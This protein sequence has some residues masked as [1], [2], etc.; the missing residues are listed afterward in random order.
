MDVVAHP[1]PVDLA[2]DEGA[3]LLLRELVAAWSPHPRRLR[4]HGVDETA[5]GAVVL[6]AAEP[7][8]AFTAVADAAQDLDVPSR[9]P[10]AVARTLEIAGALAGLGHA[11]RDVSP[12]AI[13]FD[14]DGRAVLYPPFTRVSS[15]R[16]R[17]GA[18]TVK[19]TLFEWMSP[20]ILSGLAVDTRSDVYQLGTT[21]YRLLGGPH[22]FRGPS[23]L[24]TLSAVASTEEAPP[25][26]VE[27]PGALEAA[28]ARAM[29]KSREARFDTVEELA[30][31]IAP[32]GVEGADARAEI[33]RRARPTGKPRASRLFDG[34]VQR[35]CLKKWD[36]LAPTANDAVR[37]CATCALSVQRVKTFAALVPLEGS[38]VFYD[39][40]PD[41]HG[42]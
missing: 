19:G 3:L 37:E 26:G 40:E 5:T 14:V 6:T 23:D 1:V 38:C 8:L 41:P 7:P 42:P 10:W 31:A 25:I 22:A 29:K 34:V 11:H 13:G 30:A 9:T 32:Y 27:L 4:V 24:D 18:G 12:R 20:E 35:P 17:M 15:T 2:E 36:E 39:P 16:A 33:A 21:L 28:I